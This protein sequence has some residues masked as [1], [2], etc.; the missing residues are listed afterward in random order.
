MAKYYSQ[1]DG[2][3]PQSDL[4]DRPRIRPRNMTDA[5]YTYVL[6][7][8]LSADDLLV[9][10]SRKKNAFSKCNHHRVRYDPNPDFNPKKPEGYEH[11]RVQLDHNGKALEY[12]RQVLCMFC[13]RTRFFP[14]WG[15][16]YLISHFE[17]KHIREVPEFVNIL[18][19]ELNLTIYAP[20]LTARE[21]I[22]KSDTIDGS[23]KL[24]RF[25]MN[26]SRDVGYSVPLAEVT[27]KMVHRLFLV[28]CEMVR[29][30]Y[31]I[32]DW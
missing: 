13:A 3:Y 19:R 18:L 21:K 22:A 29:Q 2:T 9:W 7:Y 26:H 11:S 1:F 16:D 10:I 23:R 32:V 28:D 20:D 24:I 31:D 30:L 27:E 25:H 15:K 4:I 14:L 17:K 6:P 8:M 12:T 5:E